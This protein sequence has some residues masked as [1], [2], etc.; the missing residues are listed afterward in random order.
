MKQKSVTKTTHPYEENGEHEYQKLFE[1]HEYTNL[2]NP[3]LEIINTVNLKD[4]SEGLKIC[5]KNVK[6]K[7][8]FTSNRSW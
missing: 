2:K 3:L 4:N 1:S 5:I 7:N 6:K 8:T